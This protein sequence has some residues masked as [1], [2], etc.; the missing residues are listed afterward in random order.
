V[1]GLERDEIDA[2]D[3]NQRGWHYHVDYRALIQR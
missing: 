2:P 1:E 3:G